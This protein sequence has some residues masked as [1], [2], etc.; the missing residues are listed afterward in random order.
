MAAQNAVQNLRLLRFNENVLQRFA[1]LEQRGRLAHA[2][3]FA[4]P[5]EIGKRQTALAVAKLLNCEG[6]NRG[7]CE[8]NRTLCEAN[9]MAGG[10]P[11]MRPA[12]SDEGEFKRLHF[13][14]ACPSCRR[15]TSGNHPDVHV[16]D[17]SLEE[18]MTIEDVRGILDQIKLRPFMAQKKIFILCNIENLTVEGVN[19]LLKTLEEPS[20]GSLLLLTTS[21]MEKI[22]ETVRSRCH[23]ERFFRPSERALAEELRAS[24]GEE[25]DRAHVLAYLAGGCPGKARRLKEQGIFKTRDEIIDRFLLSGNREAMT[26][27]ILADKQKV[28]EFLDILLI[29]VRDCLLIKM[30]V[31][32][33]RL[34]HSDRLDD[35]KNFQRRFTFEQ[36]EKLYEEVVQTFRLLADNLNVKIPLLIIGEML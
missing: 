21:V 30:G 25:G 29:W 32:E 28:R 19:A 18:P 5:P 12:M 34:A 33:S 16:I 1:S 6:R 24:Y 27:N 10:D 35:L 20:P 8:G 15:I 9:G 31:A 17:S 23:R 13:C 14:D 3:L 36:L 4:G 22:P 26:K 11:S 2:Y 7:F